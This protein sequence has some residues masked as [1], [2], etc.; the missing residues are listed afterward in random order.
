MSLCVDLSHVN[1][2]AGVDVYHTNL[3]M[4]GFAGWCACTGTYIYLRVY[5]RPDTVFFCFSFFNKV[6]HSGIDAV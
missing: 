6:W 1:M 4:C 3:R 2:H 5:T